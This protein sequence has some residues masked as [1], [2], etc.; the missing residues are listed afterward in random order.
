MTTGLSRAAFCTAR[1]GLV[2]ALLGNNAWAQ[3]E[4]PS[5][6]PQIYTCID[7]SGRKLNSDRPIREC[8]G[9]EQ[10]I[11][12]PS[13]TVKARL[14]PV[15][16]AAERSQSEAKIKA[17]EME[18]LK[19]DEEKR[20][21]RSLLVRYPN[22]AA[23]QK[24][25]D[26]AVAQLLRAR[27][28]GETRMTELLAEQAKLAEEMAFYAKDPSKA[29]AKLQREVKALAQTLADQAAFLSDKDNEIKRVNAKF[30]E[31]YKRLEP[32]WPT[33]QASGS[34]AAAQ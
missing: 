29:P 12:N 23:H 28:V 26:E 34:P 33:S 5:S 19:K 21:N 1:A 17:E 30:D 16:T 31:E 8:L 25:R 9:R 14:G 3:A 4:G 11:L 32:L 13:G 18:R 27:Q 24:Y 22:P 2:L 15:Q 6:T 20:L 10:T 7:A